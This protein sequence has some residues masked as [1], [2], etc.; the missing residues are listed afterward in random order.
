[1][2]YLLVLILGGLFM[3]LGISAE[4]IKYPPA[5]RLDRLDDYHGTKVP[6][7]YHWLEDDVRES[8]AVKTWVDEEN[9]ITNAYL[10]TIPERQ[11]I[12]KRLTELWNYERYS[13]PSKIGGR[14]FFR[15][16]DGLQNQAVL[17]TMDSL[18]AAPRV[19]LNPNEW[20]KDGTIALGSTEV[21][22]DGKYLAYSIS[23]GGSDW[24]TW[25]VL[26]VATAKPLSDE[27]KWVKFSEVSWTRD[28]K[29]FF[30]SRYPEPRKGAEFQSLNKNQHVMYHRIGT[31]QSE[32]VLV[33]KRADQPDWG[34]SGSVTDD[35]RYL[36][37]TTWVG[38]DHKNRLS[39]KDLSEPYGAIID[40]ADNFELE[41]SVIDNDGPIFYVKTDWKA[42]NGRVMA[43]DVR[44][45]GREHWKE[46]IPQAKDKLEY[47]HMV[48]NLFIV[49]YLQDA[50]SQVK[51]FSPEGTFVREVEFPGIGSVSGFAGRRS[52][53]ETFYSFSSYATP[54]NIY[55]YDIITGKSKLWRKPEVKFNPDDYEVN[56]VF[57]TSKDGTKIPMFI[58]HKKGLKRDGNNPTLLYG[59]GGFDISLTPTFSVGIVDW[60]E[61]GGIYVVANLRGGGEYGNDWHKAGTKLHKQN[62]F[63]DFIGS[64]EYLIREKY[65]STPKLAIKGGSNGGLL[66]G[67]VMTQRP[68]LFGACLPH[69]GVM[70]MLRFNKFTAGRY[71]VD[72]YGSSANA[73][74]FKAL[75]AYS[76]YHNLKKGV[77]Y[78]PTMVFTADTDDRVV[79]G[80]SFKF[81]AQLQYCQAGDAPVLA[82]IETRAGHGAGKPTT[83]LIDELADEYAFLVKNL[84]MSIK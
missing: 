75:Y 4:P 78:P 76:P 14:Y 62:V 47:A 33:Y 55:H 59:Y 69:V 6:D 9:Q 44:Q 36:I 19:L 13:V 18:G 56:Q 34:F 38:T 41:L 77:H 81:A 46:I 29:G 22:P 63:D 30:Y 27:L 84:K 17:Y 40:I 1:M 28:D 61:M 10:K 3:D 66:I 2:R 7:P 37:I 65:T 21:S 32:D 83:K 35:G 31:A 8:A 12:H 79:P 50:K 39:Y 74:E 16:N 15:K 68:D 54:T 67:A 73:D 11:Q 57:S 42:P 51:L 52:D 20:T 72:D 25:K 45:L 53:T 82:R 43:V 26:D 5:K 58:T 70:D 23:E 24:Q 80:H 48:G 71:W 49:G 60:M 64:A